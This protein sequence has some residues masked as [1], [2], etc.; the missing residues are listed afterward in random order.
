MAALLS[1]GQEDMHSTPRLSG[2][3][4]RAV[5]VVVWTRRVS[6][7]HQITPWLLGHPEEW[8]RVMAER[9]RIHLLG[10]LKAAPRDCRWAQE[11][12]MRD[13]VIM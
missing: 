4:D 11:T 3:K 6:F 1:S 8:D 9:V 13:Y 10:L 5:S 7:A 2:S 12:R